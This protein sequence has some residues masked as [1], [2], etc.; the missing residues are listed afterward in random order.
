MVAGALGFVACDIPEFCVILAVIGAI[1]GLLSGCIAG[2]SA[3]GVM[4]SGSVT[5]LMSWA[6]NP[7][8]LR[9]THPELHQ[10]FKDV[11]YG[12]QMEAMQGHELH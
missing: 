12:K 2:G 6:E 1:F 4:N 5:I 3:V 7:D 8:V 10:K 9:S 11:I